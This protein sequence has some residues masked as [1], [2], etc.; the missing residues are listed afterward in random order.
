MAAGAEDAVVDAGDSEDVAEAGEDA[1]AE[2][3]QA[4]L[5]AGR[6]ALK[7]CLTGPGWIL[8][9]QLRL[10]ASSRRLIQKVVLRSYY[11]IKLFK[12]RT[13]SSRNLDQLSKKISPFQEL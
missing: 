9:C 13:A 8:S 6:A 7:L 2:A 10:L 4:E 1:D 11:I 5:K 12:S 3:R